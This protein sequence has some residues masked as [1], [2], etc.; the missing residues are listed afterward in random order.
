ME[1]S[2]R[3]RPLRKSYKQKRKKKDGFNFIYFFKLTI[4]VSFLTF[5]CQILFCN[6]FIVN[7][8]IL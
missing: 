2:S 3:E 8:V 1:K 7:I 6:Q 4:K 5:K